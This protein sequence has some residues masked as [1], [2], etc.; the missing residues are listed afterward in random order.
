MGGVEFNAET[1]KTDKTLGDTRT[2]TFSPSVGTPFLAAKTAKPT[3]T[4]TA[5][6]LPVTVPAIAPPLNFFSVTEMADDAGVGSLV[7]TGVGSIA[8]ARVRNGDD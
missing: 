7:G 8:G 5:E 3:I 4:A 1:P 6:R 2:G